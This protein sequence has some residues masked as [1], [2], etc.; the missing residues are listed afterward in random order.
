MAN[1]VVPEIER[2]MQAYEAMY[3]RPGIGHGLTT[4][5]TARST[6]TNQRVRQHSTSQAIEFSCLTNGREVAELSKMENR[7]QAAGVR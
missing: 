4:T 3:R 2:F 5:A 6:T 1:K 7:L